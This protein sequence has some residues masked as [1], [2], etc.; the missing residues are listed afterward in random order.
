MLLV[1]SLRW[2]V[3]LVHSLV[4]L[5]LALP[6][7]LQ[8]AIHLLAASVLLGAGFVASAV[9]GVAST[10]SESVGSLARS[11]FIGWS[12]VGWC[13]C[14]WWLVVML[15]AL[16]LR[17]LVRRVHSLPWLLLVLHG[18]F[19]MVFAF[20]WLPRCLM[21]ALSRC[22]FSGLC[23]RGGCSMAFV[24]WWSPCLLVGAGSV[25]TAAAVAAANF[26]SVASRSVGSPACS[27]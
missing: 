17:L 5:L 12:F 7:D 18:G 25:A 3:C 21:L 26:A 19:Q 10:T 14:T 13:V 22:C 15:V 9:A 24:F 6:W 8:A 4:R 23:C 11:R 20:W 2:L 27:C 16:S 1:L